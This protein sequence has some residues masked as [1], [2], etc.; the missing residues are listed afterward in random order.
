MTRSIRPPPRRITEEERRL[1]KAVA[2]QFVPLTKG[3]GE[4]EA[5]KDGGPAN[6]RHAGVSP[7]PE[8]AR[9]IGKAF[10]PAKRTAAVAN[11]PLGDF[12]PRRARRLSAGRLPI[13]ARLDLHG[14]RQ[15]DAREALMRFLHAAQNNGLKHVKVITGKGA[16][17]S[18]SELQAFSLNDSNRRGV[19]REQVPRWLQDRTARALVVSFTEA[20]RGHGGSGAL[21]IQIRRKGSNKQP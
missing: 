20:A 11:P 8:A 17:N 14:M 12:E 16:T 10:A 6:D 9:P 7:P 1:W 19:L 15:D 5:G 3:K 21:Y 2:K 4:A 13:E 18:G